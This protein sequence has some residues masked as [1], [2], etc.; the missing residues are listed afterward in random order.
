MPEYGLNL[1][2]YWRIIYKRKWII[3]SVFIVSMISAQFFSEKIEPVYKASVTLYMGSSK[4][5][6]AEI[7]GTGVTFW[8]GAEENIST[9]LELIK[10]YSVL[11]DVAAKLGL[12]TKDTDPE[13]EEAVINGLR[14]KISAVQQENTDLVEIEAKSTNPVEAKSV[15][16]TVANVFIDKNWERKVK[17]ASNTKQFVEKQLQKIDATI[18]DLKKKLAVQGALPSGAFQPLPPT[19]S[20]LRLAQLKL[21]LANLQDRFTDNYP[22]IISLKQEIENIGEQIGKPTEGELVVEEEYIDADKLQ[23]ELRINQSLYGMLKERYEKARIL[24]AS[25]TKDI[26]IVNP[27]SIPKY[28]IIVQKT[29]NIFLGGAIGIVLGLLAAFVT[30]SLDTSIG[31]IEDVEEYLHMPVLGVVPHMDVSKKEEVDFFKEPLPPEEKKRYEDL[32][33][34]MVIQFRPK[35]S[36]AEAYR[37]L[38]TYIKFSGIDKYGNCVMFTSAGIREGKTITSVN[39]ALSMAQLGYKVVLVDADLRR[40]SVHRV[41]GIKRQMGLTEAVLGTFRVDEVIK[42]MDDVMMGNIKSSVIMKTYGMENLHIITAGHLP[43]NPTEILS[44]A[45]M[46]RFIKELKEKFHVVFIDSAPVLPVTDTCILSSKVDSVILVYEV[47]RVS[48]GALRRCKMQIENAKGRAVGVV[49]NN[50]RISDMRFGSPFYYYAQKYYGEEPEKDEGTRPKKF[51]G[52][53]FNS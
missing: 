25:K 10:S 22:K 34:R 33:S 48:R 40:P 14:G 29:T 26:E 12:L 43:G 51:F 30:E 32:V 9:Q 20:K 11:K 21:E 5:P 53:E 36:I 24:E 45:N 19:D 52:K 28:P 18:T 7:T 41:F 2:D 4:T 39:S 6:V 35:S 8:G 27:A 42:T 46:T 50:M 17:E 23:N 38:Q 1:W 49:L 31:T 44:S 47:G 3:L 13:K 16:E 15:A 37:N